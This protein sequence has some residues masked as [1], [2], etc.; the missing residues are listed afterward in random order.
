MLNH[1]SMFQVL[2]PLLLSCLRENEIISLKLWIKIPK[3]IFFE[4]LDHP[5][6]IPGSQKFK[7]LRIEFQVKTVNLT[8]SDTVRG[9]L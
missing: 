9:P 5:F 3:K 8:S 4:G 6:S 1:E 2:C 7:R